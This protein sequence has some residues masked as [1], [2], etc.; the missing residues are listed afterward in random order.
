MDDNTVNKLTGEP[1][2]KEFRDVIR[3]LNENIHVSQEEI[4]ELPEIKYAQLC[5]SKVQMTK[6]DLEERKPTPLLRQTRVRKL[7]RILF[8]FRRE[9]KCRSKSPIGAILRRLRRVSR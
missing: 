8:F 3:R 5:V 4:N 6:A 7:P 1:V 2:S 9:K